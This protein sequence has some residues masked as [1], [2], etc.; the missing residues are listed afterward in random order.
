MR[1]R[2]GYSFRKAVG[3]VDEVIDR[4]RETK[5]EV[6]PITDTASTF[7]YVR[8]AKAAKAAGLRPIFG[9]ELAVTDALHAKRPSV[10]YW[11]FIAKDDL[12]SV[13]KLVELAGSQFRY[14]PLLHTDQAMAAEGV[15]KIVGEKTAPV[16]GMGSDLDLFVAASPSL[17]RGAYKRFCD[18]GL[19]ER[20][21][22]CPDN[23]YTSQ[24]D[25]AMYETICGRDAFTQTYP[26][27][28]V[29]NDEWSNSLRWMGSTHLASALTNRV[30]AA[31][32]C[33]AELKP[34][35]LFTPEHPASLREMCEEGAKELGCDLSDPVYAER[36]DRELTLIADKKFEDYF[37]IIADMCQWARKRMIVGPARGSSC[38]SLV[39]YLLKITTVDPIPYDL[40]FERFIDINRSDLPDI[41][42]DFSD[43]KRQMVFDY[44]A[45]KYG[46]DHVARLGTVS[47]YRPRSCLQEARAALDIPPWE[48]NGVLDSIIERSG[49]DS[50]ALQATED[51][52][53]D[54][55]AG[56]KLVEKHPEI[57]IAGRMEGHPRH[58]SQHAAGIV[59]TQEPIRKYVAVDARTGATHC[60]KKD[61]EELELL[62]IDALGLTQLSIFED[63]L[64]MAG[65][66]YDLLEKVPLNDPK[67]FA[68]LNDRRYSGVFQF[69][70]PALKSITDQIEVKSLEDI[71]SIT[72]LGRPGPLNTGG[73]NTWIKRKT[74]KEKVE[75][76]H[77]LFKP[78]L[79]NSLGIVAYQEQVMEIGRKVGD[80]SWEDV[81]AL[82][83]AMSKSLGKEYFD[84][85]GDRWKKNAISKGIP[86]DVA[87]KV[88]DDL[89]AYGSWAFNRSHAVAYGIVSY[90]CCWLKAHYPAEFAAATL[91]HTND[92][93]KQIETLREMANEGVAYVPF[94]KELSIDKWTV[95][96]VDGKGKALIGPATNVRGLGPKMVAELMSCRA[97][98]EEPTGR[99]AKLMENPV[100]DIDSLYPIRD[101]LQQ[102]MPD[103]RERNIHTEPRKII[104]VQT[105]GQDYS[106]LVFC[107]ISQI[108][109]KDENEQINVAKRGYKFK[110]MTQSLNLRLKDDTDTMFAKVDRF[111]FEQIGRG[112]IERGRPGKALYAIKGKVP[113]DFRMIRVEM[114]RY[115]G[116]MERD[117]DG[118]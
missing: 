8:W 33:R 2:T 102:I 97:R 38:G 81:T 15:V 56:R 52:L 112:I 118:K 92:P 44:M 16:D 96:H 45:E 30:K 5:W 104:D 107:V 78:H 89:C 77:P 75:Y 58:H 6:A 20:F 99:L 51:T 50:R 22:A 72:A 10:D 14:Q 70:G 101:R 54:T 80:L 24:N 83:K 34:G 25:L 115:L 57:L 41:D 113:R 19:S 74:G 27:W 82:R 67:A 109:P 117:E 31:D 40:I 18:A 9:V 60:D 103:P 68:V 91:T 37:Y 43:T 88:W 114:V 98:G 42:I 71:V 100:T 73:T 3:H 86:Q 32:A 90:H 23:R 29:D 95:G 62:K 93:S 76:P 116:D 55:D 66:P 85:F 17:S 59:L 84:Q 36:L 79:E 105:I 13:H 7:G 69:N 47:L 4:L 35:T 26:Q 11:T 12:E 108:K 39:C 28:I 61:A 63:T 111:K 46:S 48:I 65:Q 110:S 1:I 87:E 94:D 106:V 64:S 21:I 53:K 49:G